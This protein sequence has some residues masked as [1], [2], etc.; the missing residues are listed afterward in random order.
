MLPVQLPIKA[1]EQNLSVID[2]RTSRRLGVIPDMLRVQQNELIRGMQQGGHPIMLR[3]T[4]D[5]ATLQGDALSLVDQ[6]L[7]LAR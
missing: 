5:A 7:R 1:N 2:T 3:Y 6:L 4:N